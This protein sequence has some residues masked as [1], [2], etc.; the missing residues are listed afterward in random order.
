MKELLLAMTIFCDVTNPVELD[1]LRRR[2]G[3]YTEDGRMPIVDLYRA[4]CELS[5]Q[6]GWILEELFEEVVTGEGGRISLPSTCLRTERKGPALW[7]LTGIHGE[8]PAGPNA[9]AENIPVLIGLQRKGIALVVLPLLNPLG[10]QRNWRYPDAAVYSETRPGSSVGDSEHLLP[11]PDG[12]ARR[13]APACRQAA[14][15]TARVVEL[16]REYPPRLALDLHEDNL[17]EKGYVYTQG[18]S[19]A[20]DPAARALMGLLHERGFPVLREGKTR[21]G[22]TVKEGIVHVTQDGSIDE[23]LGASTVVVD[24]VRRQGPAGAS[25]LVLETSSMNTPL[26]AR[27]KVHATVLASLGELWEK[28]GTSHR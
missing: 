18:R 7:I 20:E 1:Q 10:Y 26:P 4:Q 11:G 6:P 19:G 21:F 23:L 22:E 24:G 2:V 13:P 28:S 15:L 9:L 25:V 16:S 5:K 12:K 17:L 14:A 27:K 8:E 3:T